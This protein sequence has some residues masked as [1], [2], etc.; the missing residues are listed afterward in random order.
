VLWLAILAA[1]PEPLDGR[2]SAR[3]A[4][5]LEEYATVSYRLA[6]LGRRG[7]VEHTEKNRDGQWL[8]RITPQGRELLEAA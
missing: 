1:S 3:L 2:T 4:G 5:D 6:W 8:W 7:Y